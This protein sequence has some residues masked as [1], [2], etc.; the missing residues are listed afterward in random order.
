MILAFAAAIVLLATGATAIFLMHSDAE[1]P[2]STAQ[3]ESQNEQTAVSTTNSAG[4]VEPE[5]NAKLAV[6]AIPIASAD[7]FPGNRN[8]EYAD[9]VRAFQTPVRGAS[10]ER[11]LPSRKPLVAPVITHHSNTMIGREAAPDI[12]GPNP[13]NRASANTAAIA[14]FLPS[15]GRMKAPQLVSRSVPI[16]PAM[17]KRA[18]IEGEV[19][20]DAVVDT[21]GKLINMKVV[22][23]SPLLRQA[24][25]DSLGTWKYEPAYLDDKPVPV[26]TSITVKFRI[27]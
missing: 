22:S 6:P 20:V 23:G 15:G 5:S 3:V 4:N 25:L 11:K 21:N 24:A 19:T 18:A 10:V 12:T 8:R 9:N 26:Q 16:Y 7:N 2:A 27:H 1:Q 14:A 17:A 13:N